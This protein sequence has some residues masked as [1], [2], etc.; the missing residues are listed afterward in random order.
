MTFMGP[1]V[2][3]YSKRYNI[4]GMVSINTKLTRF[5]TGFL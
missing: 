5:G 3:M 2:G 1:E 4:T